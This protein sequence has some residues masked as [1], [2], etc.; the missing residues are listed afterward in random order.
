MFFVSQHWKQHQLSCDMLPLL[1]CLFKFFC[2]L[3]SFSASSCEERTVNSCWWCRRK[4]KRNNHGGLMANRRMSVVLRRS[5]GRTVADTS[6]SP[7]PGF[8]LHSHC[9]RAGSWEDA[10][11]WRRLFMW[12]QRIPVSP[13]RQ[14]RLTLSCLL[15]YFP[16]CFLYLEY[17]W[18][19][20]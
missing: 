15:L 7:P 18:G 19:Q 16:V 17:C 1:M 13:T 4:W 12:S 6:V 14:I 5:H 20:F 11:Q 8:R 9:W 10:T 2:Y 3:G